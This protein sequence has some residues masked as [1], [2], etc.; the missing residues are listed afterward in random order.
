[1]KT[2]VAV[3]LVTFRSS[4]AMAQ[5]DLASFMPNES[6]SRQRAAALRIPL[7]PTPL[8]RGAP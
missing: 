1:M 3:R 7:P 5:E 2:A 4:T 8:D 6:G